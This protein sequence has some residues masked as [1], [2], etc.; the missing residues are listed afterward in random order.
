MDSA[1]PAARRSGRTRPQPPSPR[2]PSRSAD[3]ARNDRPSRP[4]D[5]T[6]AP[7]PPGSL[8]RRLRSWSATVSRE[9]STSLL[10]CG[11]SRSCSVNRQP[12]HQPATRSARSSCFDRMSDFAGSLSG[13]VTQTA[14]TC[15]LTYGYAAGCRTLPRIRQE[16]ACRQKTDCS[17]PSS[18][19][20]TSE[21]SRN[22]TLRP[23]ITRNPIPRW[24]GPADRSRLC[25]ACSDVT[26]RQI[27]PGIR[28][29]MRT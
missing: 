7:R 5:P 20:T 4:A 9:A 24:G 12:G 19:A 25:P 13:A 8:C 23:G 16:I 14:A 17:D 29:E 1:R 2:R 26:D 3:T 18:K 6:P 10:N 27:S 28:Q 11:N 15:N 21:W 22:D